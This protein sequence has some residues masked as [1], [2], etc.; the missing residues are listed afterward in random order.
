MDTK[1]T[2]KQFEDLAAFYLRELDRF[3]PEDFIRKPAPDQWSLAQ[4]YN[5]AGCD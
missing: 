4:M 5:Q 2:L 1:K 3:S